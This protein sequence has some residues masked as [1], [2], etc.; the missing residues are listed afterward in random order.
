MSCHIS[1]QHL[2][3]SKYLHQTLQEREINVYTVTGYSPSDINGCNPQC[4]K[5]I[6]SFYVVCCTSI[7]L[8]LN[9]CR[10]IDDNMDYLDFFT[11]FSHANYSWDMFV[12]K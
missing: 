10:I 2:R 3:F 9:F 11:H 6:F 4:L 8:H 7:S 1:I 5:L 12:I